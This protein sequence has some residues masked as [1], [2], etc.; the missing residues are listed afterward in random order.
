M[1]YGYN[2]VSTKEQHLDRGDAAIKEFCTSRQIPLVRIYSDKS[3]GRSFNE[4]AR[5]VVLKG[6]ILR[7]NDTLILSELD[8]LGRTKKGIMAELIDLK[9]MGV[10]VM[11]LD[12]PTTLIDF[13]GF[14]DEL[15]GLMLDTIN[16]MLIEMYA[17][18]A[19][20]EMEKK[21]K[22]RAEGIQAMKD[23]GEWDRYGR[24]RKISKNDFAAAYSRVERGEVRPTELMREL[25][26]TSQT[27]YRYRK[28]YLE[29]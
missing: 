23:R 6:D 5:W 22:R 9:K 24:P 10:R 14:G 29:I 28:E 1:F 16:N 11:I 2:R 21:D 7:R 19:Q 20:A 3:S 25:G 18:L 15:A 13:S 26:L 12:I 4:R 27:Y 17:A 8:R